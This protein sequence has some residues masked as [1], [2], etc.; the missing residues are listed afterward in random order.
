MAR[1]DG[2]A[3]HALRQARRTPA[4][5]RPSLPGPRR[6]AGQLRAGEVIMSSRLQSGYN[7]LK[8]NLTER[9]SMLW[10]RHQT[11]VESGGKSEPDR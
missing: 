10:G 1:M 3:G 8:E 4:P 5:G 2:L 7:S 9:A 11:S 6:R